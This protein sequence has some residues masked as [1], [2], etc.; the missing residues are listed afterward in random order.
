MP[1]KSNVSADAPQGRAA[2]R[3][4]NCDVSSNCNTHWKNGFTTRR[5]HNYTVV[6]HYRPKAASLSPWW[7]PLLRGMYM[8]GAA[9]HLPHATSLHLGCTKCAS[10]V[11]AIVSLAGLYPQYQAMPSVTHSSMQPSQSMRIML[12][13]LRC[14]ACSCLNFSCFRSLPLTAEKMAT[15][16]PQR[17]HKPACLVTTSSGSPLA[18]IP[19]IPLCHL[20]SQG[21]LGPCPRFSP[22]RSHCAA[23]RINCP[24]VSARGPEY[25]RICTQPEVSAISEGAVEFK[26]NA[27]SSCYAPREQ[28]A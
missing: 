13:C 8:H 19:S 4:S 15:L 1:A 20:T 21:L 17:R 26:H 6:Y 2:H 22:G 23:T 14:L 24:G 9:Q 3:V 11:A 10:V 7:L 28:L 27:K 16:D 18:P 5:H 12:A 25:C